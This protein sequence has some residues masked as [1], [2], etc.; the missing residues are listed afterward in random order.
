MNRAVFEAVSNKGIKPA[1]YYL[2]E[3]DDSIWW[4]VGQLWYRMYP[5]GSC[6]ACSEAITKALGNPDTRPHEYEPRYGAFTITIN[7]DE[8]D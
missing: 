5:D 7:P 2:S 8:E 3:K 4:K 1:D 6:G